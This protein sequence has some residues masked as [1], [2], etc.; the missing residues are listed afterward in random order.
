MMRALKGWLSAFR[1]THA[2]EVSNVELAVDFEVF[3]GID[4]PTQRGRGPLQSIKGGK[5]SG[6]CYRH[7]VGCARISD[8]LR[9]CLPNGWSG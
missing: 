9:R 6:R 2:G 8:Y 7:S 3:T 5:L 4:I 1:W